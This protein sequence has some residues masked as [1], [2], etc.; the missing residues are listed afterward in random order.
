MKG[1][2]YR[3][4]FDRALA[5]NPQKPKKKILVALARRATKLMF[6]VARD[7]RLYTPDGPK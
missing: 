7:R 2:L 6:S 3:E 4:A 1:G 5:E